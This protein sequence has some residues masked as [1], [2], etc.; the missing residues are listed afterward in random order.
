MQK[1]TTGKLEYAVQVKMNK[2]LLDELEEIAQKNNIPRSALIRLVLQQYVNRKGT[3]IIKLGDD[4][5]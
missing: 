1:T 2:E 5:K 3:K 4:D